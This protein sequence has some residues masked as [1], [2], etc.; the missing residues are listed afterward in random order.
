MRRLILLC[1][2]LCFT[3]LVPLAFGQERFLGSI[4]LVGYNFAQ[5]GTVA[6]NGQL[7]PI[8]Q[9]TALFELIGTTYGGDGVQTFAVPDLRGRVP[10]GQGQGLGLS[11]KIIGQSAGEEQVTLTVNQLPGHTHQATGS[12]AAGNTVSPSGAYWALGPRLN[13]YSSATSLVA[14]NPATTTQ[15]GGNQPHD[16]V[17]PYLALNYEIWVEGIF[18]SR[19]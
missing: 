11:N 1:V 13:L 10:I 15:V 4:S 14:M 7:L 9:F 12:S 6:C 17:K 3:S 16:N 19:D 5:V 2:A 18:P 8:S